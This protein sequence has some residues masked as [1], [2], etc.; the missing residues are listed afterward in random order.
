MTRSTMREHIFKLLFR[1]E[2][3]DSHELEEQIRLYMNELETIKDDDLKY[4][5][6][7]TLS[8]AELIP[9]IDDK[10]NSVSEGWPVN[11]LGKAE[12]AIM[13]LAV[14]EMLYDED[15]P[16]GVAINEAVELAKNYGSDS[17]PSFI[18]GVLA[19]L[20]K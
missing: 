5:T 17:A 10:I 18:N 11:R 6:E 1:V 3:H 13:R 20:T 2:F 16:T 7:K 14:Y 4:I 8:I 19:K 15:I 9:E 12:L